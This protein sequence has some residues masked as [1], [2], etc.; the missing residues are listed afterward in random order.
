MLGSIR[1]CKLISGDFVLGLDDD[2]NNGIKNVGLLQ[3]VPTDMG[4]IS[5]ALVPFGF[6]FE[7]E[8]S[9]FISNDKVLYEVGSVPESLVSK[10]QEAT[11]NIKLLRD[12][13]SNNIIL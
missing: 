3:F 8:F 7:N 13:G 5:M 2:V 9:G 11:S 12:N 4:N 6:P 1:L 10:Y